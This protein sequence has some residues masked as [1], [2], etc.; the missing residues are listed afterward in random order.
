[1]N[2]V[3]LIAE[4]NECKGKQDLYK[5]QSPQILDALK[6]VAIIQS[7]E[8]SNAIENITIETKRFKAI[9][10]E[11]TAPRNRPEGEIAGY[12]DTLYISSV[13]LGRNAKWKKCT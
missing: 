9:M 2:V 1:M 8:S 11:K 3:R 7:T 5:Q 4:I 6:Q 12:R 13:A 10:A